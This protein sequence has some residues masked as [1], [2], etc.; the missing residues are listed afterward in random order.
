MERPTGAR[1]PV[2]WDRNPLGT[3]RGQKAPPQQ[4]EQSVAVKQEK[5]EILVRKGGSLRDRRGGYYDM[6]FRNVGKISKQE[7]QRRVSL[8]FGNSKDGAID[9]TSE[10]SSS[11]A[12]V[13]ELTSEA[14]EVQSQLFIREM[15]KFMRDMS[16]CGCEMCCETIR[17]AIAADKDSPVPGSRLFGVTEMEVGRLS[18]PGK[19]QLTDTAPFQLTDADFT[20]SVSG[21]S[22]SMPANPQTMGAGL[23]CFSAYI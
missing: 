14:L 16:D 4:A 2:G 12:L 15:E 13:K 7:M 23:Q 19:L 3:S 8:V 10:V 11:N 21:P 17:L 1:C 6:D 22:H 20:R 9:L 5:H 18:D